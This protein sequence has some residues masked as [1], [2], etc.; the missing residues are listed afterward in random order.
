V[1]GMLEIFDFLKIFLQENNI[2]RLIYKCIPCIYHLQPAEADKYALFRNNA[3]L[4][5]RDVTSTIY[6][7]NKIDYQEQRKRAI[8]KGIKNNLVVEQSTNYIEYWNLLTTTLATQHDTKPVHSLEEII[9]LVNV[10][11][12]NIKL[13]VAK[14][15]E[16]ILGGTVI[17][18]N[19]K[20]AHTQYLANSIYGREI[21]ALDLVIDHLITEVYKNKKYFDFG[22]SNENNGLYLNTGLIAQKEGFGGRAVVHDVYELSFGFV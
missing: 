10:F 19:D 12:N 16:K 18:E 7:D 2:N 6:L 15:E 17:F 1:E 9:Y 4:I 20:I 21:G 8:K 3:K 11:P 5:R 13:Y 22:I 14:N